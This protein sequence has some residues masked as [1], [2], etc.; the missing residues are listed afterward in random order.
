MFMPWSLQPLSKQ[1]VMFTGSDVH[2]SELAATNAKDILN[3]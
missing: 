2:A 3:A 1:A